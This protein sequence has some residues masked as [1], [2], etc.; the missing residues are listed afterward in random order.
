MSDVVL[1]INT[2]TCRGSTPAQAELQ[3]LNKA[4]NLEMYGVDM[5]TVLGKDG[6]EYSLGLTPTGILVYEGE[7]KIGLFIWPK[8]TKLDFKKKKLTLVVVEDD[9][10]GSEQEHTFVF[11]SVFYFS[12]PQNLPGGVMP[13][14]S[15]LPSSPSINQDKS[16]TQRGSSL[17][18][19]LVS[20][21]N[22]LIPK[23]HPGRWTRS[24]TQGGDYSR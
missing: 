9:D 2:L 17:T 6:S 15:C 3:Y 4:K 23:Q 16:I 21:I 10:E 24:S 13:P 11:R 1:N 20:P 7:T 5:H 8:I 14:S 22:D 19:S 18:K 12:L